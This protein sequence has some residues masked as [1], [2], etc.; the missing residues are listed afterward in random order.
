M[1]KEFD[2]I[3]KLVNQQK[4]KVYKGTMR[5]GDYYAYLTGLFTSEL[6]IFLGNYLNT[7]LDLEKIKG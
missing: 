4:E 5:S 7:D 2:R 3:Q 1:P 6:S